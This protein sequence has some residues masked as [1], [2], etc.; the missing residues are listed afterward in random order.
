MLFLKGCSDVFQ[1]ERERIMSEELA[2][3]LSR[4]E[5]EKLAEDPAC[6]N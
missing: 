6:P 3:G 5:A 2:G 4:K 1:K